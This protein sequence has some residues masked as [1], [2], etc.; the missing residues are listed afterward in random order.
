MKINKIFMPEKWL[1]AVILRFLSSFTHKITKKIV[2]TNH[3]KDNENALQSHTYCP[4]T[5]HCS[6]IHIVFADG[7]QNIL[8][9]G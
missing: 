7:Q 8:G 9:I 1:E 3:S 2:A 5:M 4:K 6:H